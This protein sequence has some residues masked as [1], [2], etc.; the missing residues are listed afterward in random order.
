MMTH[1]IKPFSEFTAKDSHAI[2]DW[3]FDHIHDMNVDE[4]FME[5]EGENILPQ[6]RG[7]AEYLKS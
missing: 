7:L 4:E 5:E 3:L 1:K 2:A 6:L